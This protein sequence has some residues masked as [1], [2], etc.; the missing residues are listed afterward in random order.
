MSGY[1]E[2][3]SVHDG[4][5]QV[6]LSGRFPNE[7]LQEGKNAFQPLIDACS[8]HGCRTVLIDARC[9]QVSFSTMELLELGKDAAYLRKLGLRVAFLAREDMLDPF[10]DNVAF[11]RGAIIG[12]FT[13]L[14]A[15]NDWLEGNT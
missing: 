13:D 5:M 15:A 2:N 6:R 1:Y 7:L 9:L 4:V 11:N 3:F 14:S 12:V 8:E 10:F